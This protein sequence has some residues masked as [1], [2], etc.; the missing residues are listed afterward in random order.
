MLAG[1]PTSGKTTR[2]KQL[3]A[4]L[5]ERIQTAGQQ[6]PKYRVHLISD[7]TLSI[8]RAVYDLSYTP[9]HTRS[10][11][12]SEKDARANFQAAVKRVLSD[13][14]I[15]ILDGLNYIKGYRYELYCFAKSLRTPSCVLQ[16]G[17]SRERAKGVNEERLRRR[18][19]RVTNKQEEGEGKEKETADGNNSNDGIK[20]G[21]TAEN[22]DQDDDEA[23]AP[24]SPAN[25]E[26]LVFRYEEPNG[27]TRWDSPLFT[28]IW[29][30]DE[31]QTR[32]VFD[33]LWDE[34][35]GDSRKIIKPNQAT[36]QRSRDVGGDYLYQLDRVTRE[37]VDH[38]FD[39]QSS[40]GGDKITIPWGFDAKG[41]APLAIQ[42]SPGQKS[43]PQLY[44]MQRDFM[45]LN[46]GGIGLENV[47]NLSS[48]DRIRKAF[49][50]HINDVF[51]K[52]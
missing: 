13:K 15:V 43:K 18:E 28:L 10:N 38:I 9:E 46:R 4:Y 34:M 47:R 1:Y 22:G 20:E 31:D 44:R 23:E 21:V 32:K 19:G 2:A 48:A 27:M 7:Q 11:T 26:N 6:L 49:V 35:A 12:A 36:V 51:D 29:E 39:N 33:S 25:W 50:N 5:T 24:Y 14:D 8:P 3:H 52:S 16:I 30:D 42:L 41:E 45:G 17:C 40:E 37:I